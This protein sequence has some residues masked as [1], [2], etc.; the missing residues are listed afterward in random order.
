MDEYDERRTDVSICCKLATTHEY[1][2]W[3]GQTKHGVSPATTSPAEQR[4]T[5]LKSFI[6]ESIHLFSF[7]HSVCNHEQVKGKASCEDLVIMKI[8]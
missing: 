3:S 1:Y 5:Y 7:I 2:S 6:P 4:T 8:K